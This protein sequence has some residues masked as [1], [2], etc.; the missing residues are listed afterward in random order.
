MKKQDKKLKIEINGK[1]EEGYIVKLPPTQ[2]P[3]DFYVSADELYALYK[4]LKSYYGNK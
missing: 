1:K 4:L 2:R 3:N